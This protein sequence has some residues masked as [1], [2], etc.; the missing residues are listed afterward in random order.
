MAK[1]RGTVKAQI[2][3]FIILAIVIIVALV[4]LF[5][6]LQNQNNQDTTLKEFQPV[7]DYVEECAMHTAYDGLVYIA[8]TGGYFVRQD[9]SNDDGVA[10]FYLN[11]QNHVPTKQQ[12]AKELSLYMNNLLPFCTAGFSPFGEYTIQEDEIVTQTTVLTDKIIFKINYPLTIQ[13]GNTTTQ[14]KN[15]Q[16]EIP[17]RLATIQEVADQITNDIIQRPVCITC[18]QQIADENQVYVNMMQNDTEFLITITDPYSQ[19]YEQNYSFSFAGRYNN[20]A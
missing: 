15:F 1:K 6:F 13:K 2:T 18:I 10:Y 7:Y 16:I 11:N 20:N 5:F 19:V 3:I 12:L 14:I 8:N 17:V 4:T 9:S